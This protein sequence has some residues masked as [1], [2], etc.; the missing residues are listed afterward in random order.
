MSVLKSAAEKAAAKAVDLEATLAQWEADGTTAAVEL[1]DL[2]GRVGDE[3]LDDAGAAGRLTTQM[4]ALQS[5]ISVAQ[6]AAQAA[7]RRLDTARREL[8]RERAAELR[9]RAKKLTGI[10][11][12]R[13]K[14]TRRLLAELTAW[15]GPDYAPWR[16]PA[17]NPGDVVTTNVPFT[18][19]LRGEAAGLVERASHLERVAE[20]GTAEQVAGRVAAAPPTAGSAEAAV[21]DNASVSGDRLRA[22]T[23][24][25]VRGLGVSF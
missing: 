24:Q 11:D 5:R 7:T 9:E 3:V 10:A 22:L 8:L 19:V 18:Q 14:K 20:S 12:E 13:V 4:T 17:M 16:A 6:A 1:E 21:L 25:Q 2:R 15:E 23:A